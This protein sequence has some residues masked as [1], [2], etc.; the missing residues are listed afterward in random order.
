MF[1]VS[2]LSRSG[3]EVSPQWESGSGRAAFLNEDTFLI[4]DLNSHHPPTPITLKDTIASPGLSR[5]LTFT[6]NPTGDHKFAVLSSEKKGRLGLY[7]GQDYQLTLKLLDFPKGGQGVRFSKLSFSAD[8]S[9]IMYSDNGVLYKISTREGARPEEL[10][11]HDLPPG[12]AGARSWGAFNPKDKDVVAFQSES[13][14]RESIYIY[15]RKLKKIVGTIKGKFSVSHPDWSPDGEKLA[16]FSS[17]TRNLNSELSWKLCYI[18]YNHAKKKIGTVQS[19]SANNSIRK[20]AP[21]ADFTPICWTPDSGKIIYS[22]YGEQENNKLTVA[23]LLTG[24]ISKVSL[25]DRITINS[26]AKHSTSWNMKIIY[27][28]ISCTYADKNFYL[29]FAADIDIGE[30]NSR[31]IIKEINLNDY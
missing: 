25:G 17:L 27:S 16:F 10:I 4:Y 9:Q 5:Q 2:G 1:A 30:P 29:A 3:A 28:D 6:W 18:S 26:S 31:V 14:G 8:G 21:F 15:H 19:V 20:K 7:L 12:N 22:C 13:E 23:N 11:K 24:K